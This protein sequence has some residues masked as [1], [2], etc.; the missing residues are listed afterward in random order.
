MK[1][2]HRSAIVSPGAIIAS[3][4][5]I[6]PRAVIGPGVGIESGCSIGVGAV[7]EGD[8]KIG[9]GNTI[10]AGALVGTAPQDLA[11][12]GA[13]GGSLRIGE[14]NS[15]GEYAT[16]HRASK[17][18]SLTVVGDRCRIFPGAHIAHDA[19][20]GSDIVVEDNCLVGGH[21]SIGDGAR[22][23]ARAGIHQFVRIGILSNVMAASRVVKDVPPYTAFMSN[24]DCVSGINAAALREKG[25]TAQE[26]AELERAFALIYLKGLN[27]SQALERAEETA[28][29]PRVA[30]F[31][32]FIAASHRGISRGI[33]GRSCQD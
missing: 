31:F 17:T 23:G 10:S 8:T 21:V 25:W 28:W 16:I 33:R 2:I 4:V 7:I 13:P 1:K 24:D 11:S 22:L 9:A 32:D 15:I 30:T 19:H 18:G 20:L 6:G 26:Y 12:A 29:S 3:D 14:G 5:E 27:T